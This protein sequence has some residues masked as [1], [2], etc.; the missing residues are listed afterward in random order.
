[1]SS[2]DSLVGIDQVEST[3]GPGVGVD[4]P[5]PEVGFVGE[6]AL[7]FVDCDATGLRRSTLGLE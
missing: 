6:H 3:R 4:H 7:G 1:M 2:D 5:L